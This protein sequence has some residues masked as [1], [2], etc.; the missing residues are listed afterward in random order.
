MKT[1][2]V[3]QNVKTAYAL[4]DT[5][6]HVQQ[7]SAKT[8]I[9]PIDL[10]SKVTSLLAQISLLSTRQLVYLG[11]TSLFLSFGYYFYAVFVIGFAVVDTLMYLQLLSF[12]AQ[13][14]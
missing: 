8:V 9:E 4:L 6:S 10:K 14:A 3:I 5:V 13:Y 12:W 1:P 11:L 7:D 2:R